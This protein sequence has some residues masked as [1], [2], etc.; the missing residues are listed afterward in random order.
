MSLLDGD[1]ATLFGT[2]FAGLFRNAILDK[3]TVTDDGSGGFASMLVPTPAK[4][5]VEAVSDRARAAS[6]IPDVA[7]TLSILQAG[8][9]TTVD[10]DDQITVGGMNYRVIRVEA[11]PAGAV[12]TA[13]AVPS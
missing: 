3:S 13:I 2:A 6:G 11:D 4:V 9:G 5:M 10:L 12:W 1:L 8:L 7:V